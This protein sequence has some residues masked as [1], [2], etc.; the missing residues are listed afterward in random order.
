MNLKEIYV[1][2]KDKEKKFSTKKKP[3]ISFEIFPPKDDL[4]GE[5]LEKLLS[6]LEVLQKYK[7]AFISLTYGAGGS[8]QV[9]SIDI[10][11]RIKNDLNLEIMP[12]FTCVGSSKEQV[13][14]YLK[15]IQKFGIK[16]ILALRGDLPAGEEKLSDFQYA[17]ELVDFIKSQTDLSISVAGYP[18][19]HI[20]CENL[21]LDIKNL[22]RKVDSGADVIYT[23][24]FFDNDK[25]LKFCEL[26]QKAGINIP[27]IPGV[28][29]VMNYK[30]LGKMLSMA[31]VSIPSKFKDKLEKYKDNPEDIKKIGIEFA[32]LQCQQ[33]M[34]EHI[35]GLHIFTLNTFSSVCVILNN[36]QI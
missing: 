5:K 20:D 12:H 36:L 26:T 23:Q 7:P 22:K 25:F 29:P 8:T 17:N 13:L 3:V 19:G 28:L 15:E 1:Q 18:E 2:N 10:I 34:D 27:I 4:N 14:N 30:Q 33:L 21:D 31:K 9:N 16:N 24:M 11:K 32:S 6:H 35:K